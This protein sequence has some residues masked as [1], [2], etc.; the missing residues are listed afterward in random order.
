MFDSICFSPLYKGIVAV[1]SCSMFFYFFFCSLDMVSAVL[2]SFVFHYSR[3][4]LYV[5]MQRGVFIYLFIYVFSCLNYEHFVCVSWYICTGVYL[6][7]S[8][9]R[10]ALSS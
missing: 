6:P 2:G 8:H 1:F 10:I 5:Y 4:F 3:V 9:S 7:H